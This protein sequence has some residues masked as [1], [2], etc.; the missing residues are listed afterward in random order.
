MHISFADRKRRL[1]SDKIFSVV[2]DVMGGCKSVAAHES[3]RLVVVDGET[4]YRAAEMVYGDTRPQG[5]VHRKAAAIRKAAKALRDA[6]RDALEPGGVP[7]PVFLGGDR[8]MRAAVFDAIAGVLPAPSASAVLTAARAV[9]VDGL[10]V[11][12]ATEAAYGG[13]KNV[14]LVRRKADMVCKLAARLELVFSA[15]NI[16]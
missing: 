9:L 5:N 10:P 12:E 16:K 2:V 6:L 14:R 7:E 8:L 15:E 13:R 1:L 3:A 4:S 11:E